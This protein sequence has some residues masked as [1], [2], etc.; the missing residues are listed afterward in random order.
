[1]SQNDAS[2][3][4][5]LEPGQII[6]PFSLAGTDGM[7]HSPWTYKQREHL[8]LIF[9]QQALSTSNP[10][11]LQTLARHY[12]DLREEECAL[13]AITATPV[14]ENLQVQ[15]ALHLPFPLLA[16]P[17]G[18]VI[19]RYTQWDATTGTLVPCIILAD[20]YGAFY[21]Q[22]PLKGASYAQI[23]QDVLETLQYLNRLCT[24]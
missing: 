22:W 14:I 5:I 7:P 9:V 2:Y 23:I 12:P 20:R 17:Q 13:L 1:M 11:L 8:L 10:L 21:Q 18:K 16:D 19:A 4:S 3:A 24:P 15:E 6:P